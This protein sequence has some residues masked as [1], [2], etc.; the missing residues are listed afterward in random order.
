VSRYT[1]FAL[2]TVIFVQFAWPLPKSKQE[3]PSEEICAGTICLHLGMPQSEALS[4]L[5]AEY[6]VKKVSED[7]DDTGYILT[8]KKD[9]S[10]V[11]MNLSAADGKLKYISKD[12]SPAEDTAPAMMEAIYSLASHLAAGQ[13]VP[14]TM[15]ARASKETDADVK[16][17]FLTCGG[18][19]IRMELI[20]VKG[21]PGVQLQEV[22][23]ASD[24]GR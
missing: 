22:L 20:T 13:Q 3:S 2:F 4:A 7:K 23:Q 17:V 18:K 24:F 5:S 21:E 12:W 14:C 8:N 11:V 16:G 1:Q 9:N 6:D 15:E 19:Y 10:H